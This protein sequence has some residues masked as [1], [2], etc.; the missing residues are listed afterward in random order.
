MVTK[1]EIHLRATRAVPDEYSAV[2]FP[3]FPSAR[4]SRSS[5]LPAAARFWRHPDLPDRDPGSL[6][7]SGERTAEV[8]DLRPGGTKAWPT[9]GP[10]PTM[11]GKGKL[12]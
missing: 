8:E 12:N 9:L 2:T 6:S 10:G 3:A 1:R 5:V 4:S 11:S 7:S